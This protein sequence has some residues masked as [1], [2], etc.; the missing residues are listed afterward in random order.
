MRVNPAVL[1]QST[2][3]DLSQQ[4]FIAQDKREGTILLHLIGVPRGEA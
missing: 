3:L 4:D 1:D 2:I